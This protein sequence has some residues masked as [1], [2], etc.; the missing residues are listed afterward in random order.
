VKSGFQGNNPLKKS[1]E[2][3]YTGL[4]NEVLGCQMPEEVMKEPVKIVVSGDSISKGVI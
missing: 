4:N 3:G 2:M 1:R